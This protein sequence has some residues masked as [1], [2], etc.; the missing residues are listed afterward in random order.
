MKKLL[1]ATFILSTLLLTACFSGGSP[2]LDGKID[3]SKFISSDFSLTIPQD[4]EVVQ[5]FDNTY[6]D[7]TV[8]AI[9][10]HVKN[11]D[12]VANVNVTYSTIDSDID[13]KK[14]AAQMLNTHKTTLTDFKE[15]SHGDF[16]ITVKGDA[17]TSVLNVFEGRQG[18]SSP[19]LRFLQTY[20]YQGSN[21]YIVT[22]TYSVNEEMFA[23]EKV[24][25]TLKSFEIK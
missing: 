1:I 3:G 18:P 21:V 7:N 8:V 17:A 11:T 12:F 20:G 4:W 23:R 24:E 25:N 5:E 9:R 16:P 14:L 15:I 13:V 2:V 19:A 10:N 6:P 22:G